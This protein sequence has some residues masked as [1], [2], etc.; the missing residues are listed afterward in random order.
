MP[1]PVEVAAKEHMA[2]NQ[3]RV[4]R[5]DAMCRNCDKR[6]D[7]AQASH[8]DE[9]CTQG[10]HDF[11]EDGEWS[12]GLLPNSDIWCRNCGWNLEMIL[13]HEESINVATYE[14]E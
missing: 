1:V 4:L 3:S 11:G 7:A 5:A 6:E 14:T 13:E 2:Q 12:D 8:E 10:E 9:P